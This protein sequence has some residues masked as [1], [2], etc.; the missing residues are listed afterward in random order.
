MVSIKDDH[1]IDIITEQLKKKNKYTEN[2]I[3]AA[4]EFYCNY[5]SLSN[6][7]KI[8]IVLKFLDGARTV[9]YSKNRCCITLV[10]MYQF[11]VFGYSVR[12]IQS[13]SELFRLKKTNL[14]YTYT[15]ENMKDNAVCDFCAAF[16]WKK[17]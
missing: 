7:I 4:K 13:Y 1:F 9:N 14:K 16:Y 12:W 6:E 8:I 10:K 3:D 11:P 2:D 5:S 17:V 15:I